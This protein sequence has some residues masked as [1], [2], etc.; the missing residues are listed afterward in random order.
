MLPLDRWQ[1]L[2]EMGTPLA[3]WLGAAALLVFA[4]GGARSARR[5]PAEPDAEAGLDYT[6]NV[7]I[8]LPFLAL[9]VCG[10]FELT[11]LLTAK[12]GSVYAAY[13]ATRSW[14]VWEVEGPEKAQEKAEQ[15]VSMALA[16]FGHGPSD[17]PRPVPPR[18]DQYAREWAEAYQRGVNGPLRPEYLRHLYSH[19][20][21]STKIKVEP[22]EPGGLKSTLTY[23]YP[24]RFDLIGRLFGRPVDPATGRRTWT[25]TTHITLTRQEVLGA[26]APFG[27]DYHPEP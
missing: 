3:L 25:V 18:I 23:D 27:I 13:S 22:E 11:G 1:L 2:R 10:V 24:F 17:D 26:S 15:A 20:A 16:P 8:V 6:L 21:L 7:T 5:R 12:V 9:V 4:A 19:A 14:L